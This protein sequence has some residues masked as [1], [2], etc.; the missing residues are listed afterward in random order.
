[1]APPAAPPVLERPEWTDVRL[2]DDYSLT[3]RVIDGAIVHS[4]PDGHA[5]LAMV[6][7]ALG[8][9]A[10]IVRQEI[11]AGRPHVHLADYSGLRGATQEARRFFVDFVKGQPDLLGIV[12]CGVPPL[13][14]ISVRLG[15][16][17]H[18]IR[19][20]V[21]LVD[22][23][24]D[25][26]EVA[27]AMLAGSPRPVRLEPDRDLGSVPAAGS[28]SRP[29]WQLRLDGFTLDWELLDDHVMHGAPAG[30]M[31]VDHVARIREV[32]DRVIEAVRRTGRRPSVIVNLAGLGGT[33][34]AGRRQFVRGF[35][36]W[37]R[38]DPFEMLAFYGANSMLRGA[39]AVWT[40]FLPE[41]VVM[42][43]DL[44]RALEAVRRGAP[45]R[46]VGWLARLRGRQTQ[47]ARKAPQVDDLLRFLSNIAWEEDGAVEPEQETLTDHPLAPVFDAVRLIKAD[48]DQLF[49]ERRVAEAALRRSEERYRN[50]LDEIV[51]GYY[52][53]DFEGN[54]TFCNDAMLRI[55]GYGLEELE[56]LKARAYMDRDHAKRVLSEFNRVFETERPAR[57]L[58]WELI[59]KDGARIAVEASISLVR[60]DDGRKVG[61]RGIVRDITE[62]VR[63][64]RERE[65]LEAKLGHAQRMEAIGT[66]A[67]GIAHNFNNLLMGVQGNVSLIGRE[68]E[69]EHPI[70]SRLRTIEELVQG[71]SRLTAQLLGYARA[72][73][74]EVH[75]IDLNRLVRRTAETFALTRREIRV[76]QELAD[77]P[78]PVR[79]DRGQIEQVLLNLFVNAAEAMADGGDLYISTALTSDEGLRRR[80]YRPA[81][82]DYVCLAVR[83]TGVGMDEATALRA[84]DPFFTTKGMS[85]G[86]GLGLASVYGTVKAHGGYIEVASEVGIGSTFSVFLPVTQEPV[87]ALEDASE[88]LVTGTGTVL[89][90]DDDEAVLEACT[91]ILDHLRYSPIRA[92][93]GRR[94]LD[95]FHDRAHEID[96]VILDM[97]LPDISGGEVYDALKAIDPDVKVLLAS[98]YSI[99]G[100]A[101][102][103]LARGC[104]DF[105][106]KPFTIEQLS[107]KLGALLAGA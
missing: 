89:V 32:T 59:R 28:G 71:G 67:G 65:E 105:I 106:Q 45:R 20:N 93:T 98:G 37:L 64:E 18:L 9:I 49:R 2:A 53:I 57:A 61:F 39:I 90:V 30:Y 88:G 7:K 79:A 52:E 15:R 31:A 85:G 40:P 33:T 10:E 55:L 51:D 75:V 84:F 62:R 82:G 11:G 35:R 12:F 97:I 16:R 81:P 54:L 87:R 5:T 22:S 60:D 77:H 63:V 96:V 17:L 13:L 103:I 27:R 21:A 100:Q 14:K 74:V 34:L 107:R 1:M 25:A 26:I 91:S 56:G 68:V 4:R 42:V 29:E 41:R 83:D 44:E 86:T 19:L 23:L 72:G 36:E 78:V 73:R 99:D 24:D 76:H 50:I 94:A 101:E 8:L 95:L 43:R 38:T 70:Q 92:S 48:V 46:P 3:V 102:Q 6:E 69:L 47:V 66:L 58:G 104:D 80:Q